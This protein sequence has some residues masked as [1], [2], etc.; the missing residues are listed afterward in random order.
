M[1]ILVLFIL[2]LHNNLQHI[3]KT[4]STPLHDA[5]VHTYCFIYDLHVNIM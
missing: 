3:Y 4:I 1:P 2:L 5:R